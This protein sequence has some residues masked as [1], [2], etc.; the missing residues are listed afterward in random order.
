MHTHINVCMV[1]FILLPTYLV[2]VDDDTIDDL[3][4]T[5]TFLHHPGHSQWPL[6]NTETELVLGLV[7]AANMIWDIF[8]LTSSS[9][10]LQSRE[11]TRRRH[12]TRESLAEKDLERLQNLA[13]MKLSRQC[14]GKT[15]PSKGT[16][17]RG[18][19]GGRGRGRGRGRG[20]ARGSRPA[21]VADCDETSDSTS[22]EPDDPDELAVDTA[23][24]PPVT[25][26]LEESPP[27]SLI[28]PS[29]L[30]EPPGHVQSSDSG[31]AHL[32]D[33]SVH[34]ESAA[35]S[36]GAA[37]ASV[38]SHATIPPMLIAAPSAVSSSSSSSSAPCPVVGAAAPSSPSP[39][40]P[41]A[42]PRAGVR[43][44]VK[45]NERV[46]EWWDGRFPFVSIAGDGPKAGYG[47]TCGCHVNTSGLHAGTPC[48]KSLS[49]GLEG[50]SR[51]EAALRLKRWL[52][53]G[54]YG[55]ESDHECAR[56][57][58]VAK[59][60]VQCREYRTGVAGWSE[61]DSDLDVLIETLEQV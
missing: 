18:R 22:D 1:A 36:S 42:C 25:S 7:E 39:A 21:K 54:K 19:G 9:V 27:S 53:S 2:D 50:I 46:L 26:G 57:T 58:H 20:D 32:A 51:E 35:S 48:K 56:V 3:P 23:P 52:I 37:G 16:Q 30:V 31:Q 28:P 44:R 5:F 12:V 24:A 33:P 60:G 45:A 11:A 15:S 55:F 17:G 49:V 59:G 14:I 8:V 34:S 10:G 13:L 40:A 61:M 41:K 43:V 47:V 29:G 4:M 38:S 6:V